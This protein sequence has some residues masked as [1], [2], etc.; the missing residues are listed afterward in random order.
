MTRISI[1]W[2]LIL[3]SISQPFL[4]H[5][6]FVLF[7]ADFTRFRI[8][9]P[10]AIFN[11]IN[12]LGMNFCVSNIFCKNIVSIF[13]LHILEKRKYFHAGN[14]NLQCVSEDACWRIYWITLRAVVKQK[15][16]RFKAMILPKNL[17]SSTYFIFCWFINLIRKYLL[18]SKLFIKVYLKAHL[19]QR[20]LVSKRQNCSHLN[21]AQP[22]VQEVSWPRWKFKLKCSNRWFI[23]TQF[24]TSINSIFAI[25]VENIF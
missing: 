16:M 5:E 20:H 23:T 18:K 21:E 13:T 3:L 7:T 15:F 6:I 25:V 17:L 1:K 11:V 19:Q 9:F 14:L 12:F 4:C 24:I 2:L 22:T 10:S 8:I